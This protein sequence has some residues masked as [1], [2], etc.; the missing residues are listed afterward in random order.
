MKYQK[1]SRRELL[2]KLSAALGAG[3]FGHNTNAQQLFRSD[4][5]IEEFVTP[6]LQRPTLRH[7]NIPF[8]RG[9]GTM[10][11]TDLIDTSSE[12]FK[13]YSYVDNSGCNALRIFVQPWSFVDGSP[14]LP[15]ATLA[16][17]VMQDLDQWSKLI[18][19]ALSRNIHIVL[20]MD[21]SI[22][23]PIQRT[24]PDDNRSFWKDVS[25]RDECIQAWKTLTTYFK[26][27]AG[28]IFDILNEPHG[29]LS[30]DVDGNHAIP[31]MVLNEWYPKVV[32]AIRAIDPQRW[33]MLEPVWGDPDNFD[34]LKPVSRENILYSFHFYSPHE[35]T[36]QG[37]GEWLNSLG[38]SYPGMA[39]DSAWTPQFMWNYGRLIT[40]LLNAAAFSEKHDARIVVG[41]VGCGRDSL[42][43]SRT[44]W[45]NDALSLFEDFGFNWLFFR[46][47][48]WG[49]PSDFKAG[50]ALENAPDIEP[51]IMDYMQLNKTESI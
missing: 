34:S 22:G 24:W 8:L 29:V 31:K 48:G 3:M 28:V 11:Q 10:P 41:E 36:Y 19:W 13:R 14:I 16:E 12:V 20:T 32:D 40:K 2:I 6:Q 5:S 47:E 39:R 30:T 37:T 35:F 25:S 38:V 27:Q 9:M 17:R 1:H 50:W 21:L 49:V 42:G 18:P 15:G 44:R 51:I 45:V 43:E 23:W 7:D 46:F 33:I 26:G 4:F